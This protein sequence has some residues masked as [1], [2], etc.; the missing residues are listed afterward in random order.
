MKFKKDKKFVYLYQNNEI[1][2]SAKKGKDKL[3]SFDCSEKYINQICKLHSTELPSK[4]QV[5]S[6]YTHKN[7]QKIFYLSLVRKKNYLS[8]HFSLQIEWEDWNNMFTIIDFAEEYQ[9]ELDKIGC[10]TTFQNQESYFGMSIEFKIKNIIIQEGIDNL[11][12]RLSS[13]EKLTI[14]KLTQ[15]RSKEIITKVFNFPI[16]YE[17]IYSQYLMSFGELLFNIGISAAVSVN[18]DNNNSTILTIESKSNKNKLTEIE[19]ALYTYLAMPYIQ[20]LPTVK[21]ELDIN[22]HISNNLINQIKNL[23]KQID[24]RNIIMQ[25]S[26]ISTFQHKDLKLNEKV[27]LESIQNEDINKIK[28]FN[29]AITIGEFKYGPITIN[30]IKMIEGFRKIFK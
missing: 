1:V 2:D 27:L 26:K 3:Y 20:G 23:K 8:I 7:Y 22:N 14:H 11:V 16:G 18:N 4:I 21:N 19:N 25:N 28:I 6:E 24:Y 17:Y 10:L 13:I 29:G 9:R 5:H 12:Q 30:F 15:K